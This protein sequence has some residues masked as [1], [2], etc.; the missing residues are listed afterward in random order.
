MNYSDIDPVCDEDPEQIP[1][2]EPP[3]IATLAAL[4]FF[5]PM[6]PEAQG[7][8]NARYAWDCGV[9]ELLSLYPIIGVAGSVANR[10][11]VELFRAMGEHGDPIKNLRNVVELAMIYP[12]KEPAF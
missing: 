10:R 5:S 9:F 7:E 4:D 1:G 12:P 8:Q 3:S 6:T 2:I 11:V